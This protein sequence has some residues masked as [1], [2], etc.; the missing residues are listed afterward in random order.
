MQDNAQFKSTVQLFIGN[1]I[2]QKR[3]NVEYFSNYS[4]I[5][6]IIAILDHF[7]IENY[8]KINKKNNKLVYGDVDKR[9][10][11]YEI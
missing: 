4:T 8:L 1:I 5:Q 6:L 3:Y 7:I 11:K 10:S 9:K 2:S